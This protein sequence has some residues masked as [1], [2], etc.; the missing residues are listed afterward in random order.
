MMRLSALS[1]MQLKEKGSGKNVTT[2]RPWTAA[3]EAGDGLYLSLAAHSRWY[4]S[5]SARSGPVT[6][7]GLDIPSGARGFLSDR[8][9]TSALIEIICLDQR[10]AGTVAIILLVAVRQ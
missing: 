2:P 4:W 1:R 7:A 9:S 3:N 10:L 5:R 8:R 6:P